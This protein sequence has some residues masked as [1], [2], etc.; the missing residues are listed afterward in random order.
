MAAQDAS[1]TP[2]RF[3]P[4]HGVAR[5]TAA[6]IGAGIVDLAKGSYYANPQ[7]DVPTDDPEM[8][9]RY[10]ETL[11]P[12]IWPG[13]DMP[14]FEPAFKSLGQ[15]IVQVGVELARHCDAYGASWPCW[16]VR[17]GLR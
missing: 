15:L 13:V 5:L 12:N 10:P 1:G 9:R 16:R 3:C 17:D 4:N 14:E 11:S 6:P 8:L 2:L 7:Y